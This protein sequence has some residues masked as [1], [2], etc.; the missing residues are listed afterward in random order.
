MRSLLN[1]NSTLLK[2]ADVEIDSLSSYIYPAKGK[3][4]N[5]IFKVLFTNRCS[6]NCSYCFNNV[7]SNCARFIFKP[8]RLANMF[9]NLYKKNK[10]RGIFLS[11]GIYKTEDYSQEKILETVIFLRRR[12][13]YRGYIHAK[14]LPRVSLSLIKTLFSYVD[15]LSINLELP[16]QKYLSKV[17]NKDFLSDLFTRLKYLSRLNNEFHLSGGITTQF[18]VGAVGES[19]RE[20]LSFTEKLYRQLNLRRVYYSGFIP[21]KGIPLENVPT[22]DILRIK[23]LYEAD[24]LIRDYNF[25]SSDFSYDENGNLLKDKNVKVGYALKN[26]HLFPLDINKAGFEDLIRIPTIGKRKA[27]D[28]MALRKEAKINSFQKLEKIGISKE[29]R[30]WICY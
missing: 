17:S 14:V 1:T 30:R 27:N 13:N 3:K 21:Y 10:V 6:Y 7:K 23:R 25:S 22:A 28:V 20:I 16:A 18:V 26:I 2:S 8:Q 24:F 29:A 5:Y 19:D 12:L 15:R 11:S 4:V 9:I